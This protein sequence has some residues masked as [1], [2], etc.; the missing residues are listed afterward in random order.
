MSP[1]VKLCEAEV[2][3]TVDPVDIEVILPILSDIEASTIVTSLPLDNPVVSPVV[4]VTVVPVEHPVILAPTVEI[5]L[6]ITN[7]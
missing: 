1:L 4:T 5:K 6:L 7:L 2:I 3:V